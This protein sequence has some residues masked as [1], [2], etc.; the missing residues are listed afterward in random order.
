VTPD[1]FRGITSRA[2]VYAWMNFTQYVDLDSC[3]GHKQD[4]D[5]SHRRRTKALRKGMDFNAD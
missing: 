2:V 1:S 4:G 5:G 3:N